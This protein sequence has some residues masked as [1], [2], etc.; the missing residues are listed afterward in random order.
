M[1]KNLVQEHCYSTGVTDGSK[2][3]TLILK[4]K[5]KSQVISYVEHHMTCMQ[6]FFN[7][8]KYEHHLGK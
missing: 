7:L 5:Q 3:G 6:N 2:E 8:I 1:S 4:M